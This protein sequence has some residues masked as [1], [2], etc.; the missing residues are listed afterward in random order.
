MGLAMVFADDPTVKT[1][2]TQGPSPAPQSPLR[3]DIGRP[4]DNF[5]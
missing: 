4:V 3:S 1:V 5:N 2:P